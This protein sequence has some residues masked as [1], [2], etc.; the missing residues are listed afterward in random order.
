MG[1][2]AALGR[3]LTGDDDRTT[4]APAAV[5]SD[6]FWTTRLHADASIIGKVAILSGTAFTIVGVAPPEFFVWGAPRMR[7]TCL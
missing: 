1:V 2:S 5:V 3:M 6:R 4:A 7:R